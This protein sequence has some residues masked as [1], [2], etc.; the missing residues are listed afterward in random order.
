MSMLIQAIAAFALFFFTNWI[1]RNAVDFGYM[2]L[3]FNQPF[4]DSPAFNVA[5]RVFAPVAFISLLSAL[6][7]WLGKDEYVTDIY[8]TVIFYFVIRYLFFVATDRLLLISHWQFLF[9]ATLSIACSIIAY[10]QVISNRQFFFPTA[11]ELGSALWLGVIAFLYQTLNSIST[12]D[13]AQQKRVRA[14]VLH[15]HRKLEHR[16]WKLVDA[17]SDRIDKDLVYSV[18][19]Y[20]SLNRHIFFSIAEMAKLRATGK[21]TVGPMQVYT[22]R[23]LKHEDSIRIGIEKLIKSFTLHRQTTEQSEDDLLSAVLYDYNQSYTYESE[24]RQ[25]LKIISSKSEI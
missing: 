23:P 15:Q 18:M 12:S 3:R 14:Y 19:I 21:A 10:E 9:I 11:H 13:K 8:R 5:Y 22:D 16:H 17:F 24:I 6:F 2:S 7:Y 20:E 4:N 25:I 1:G